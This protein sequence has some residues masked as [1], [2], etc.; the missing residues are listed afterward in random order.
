MKYVPV[1]YGQQNKSVKALQ[2]GLHRALAKKGLPHQNERN[3]TFGSG[4]RKDVCRFKAAYG[5]DKSN[6]KIFGTMAW[7]KL[8]PFIGDSDR[9]LVREHK[10]A[11]QAAIREARDDPREKLAS[12]ALRVYAER[13][14]YLYTQTRPYSKSL[15]T[16]GK[17][18]D[19]S[20]MVTMCYY[21]AGLPDPNGFSFNGYG[22][23]GSLWPRGSYTSSPRAGDLAFYGYRGGATT[24]VA[25]HISYSE[26]ISFGSNPVRRLST[27]YRSDYRGS[28]S[29]L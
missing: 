7:N 9:G 3:G 28:R 10:A 16:G 25:I 17:Y 19:C 4:T 12:I 5:L 22:Y 14:R 21:M 6:C 2:N 8:K 27:R 1:K 15:F 29:Y 20:S 11:I 26:V 24:H 23:T 18:Y 13:W